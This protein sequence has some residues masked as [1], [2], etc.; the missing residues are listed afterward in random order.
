MFGGKQLGIAS[1]LIS[2][3][4][5]TYCQASSEWSSIVNDYGTSY[6]DLECQYRLTIALDDDDDSKIVLFNTSIRKWIIEFS[7]S[8]K[9]IYTHFTERRRIHDRVDQNY[10]PLLHDNEDAELK[11]YKVIELEKKC[12]SRT[13]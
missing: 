4:F 13:K 6:F 3:F 1:I 2:V 10:L 12:E 8:N 7:M 9:P 5:T 11:K